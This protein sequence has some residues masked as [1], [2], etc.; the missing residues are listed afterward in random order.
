MHN[1]R[2]TR[3]AQGLTQVQLAAAS[4]V[5]QGII[6]YAEIGKSSPSVDAAARLAAALDTTVDDLV[7]EREGAATM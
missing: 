2:E 6:S 4:G 7:R 5:S 3:K 1:L